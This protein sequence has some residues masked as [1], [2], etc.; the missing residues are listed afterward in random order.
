MIEA[1]RAHPTNIVS[2]SKGRV[3][4]N[5]PKLPD[6]RLTTH[7]DL[8][9]QAGL[10]KIDW[11]SRQ[12]IQRMFRIERSRGMRQR[13]TAPEDIETSQRAIKEWIQNH[14]LNREELEKRP[15]YAKLNKLLP[16]STTQLYAITANDS[17]FP[18][19][20]K[21]RSQ[22]VEGWL[23]MDGGTPKKVHG[24]NEEKERYELA[25][26]VTLPNSV[27][28]PSPVE[29]TLIRSRP[30]RNGPRNL[31]TSAIRQ[32]CHMI[33]SQDGEVERHFYSQNEKTGDMQSRRIIMAFLDNENSKLGINK[34]SVKA[35]EEAGFELAK[36]EV[37][38]SDDERKSGIPDKDMYVL[39]WEKLREIRESIEKNSQ[40]ELLQ[41]LQSKIIPS[42]PVPEKNQ[43]EELAEIRQRL[44]HVS[45][46]K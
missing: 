46:K 33:A 29:L 7:H 2:D 10:R 18:N 15:K 40:S 16:N 21:R 13:I 5:K 11:N 45:S 34:A 44:A 36:K 30:G 9:E 25:M 1:G 26:N 17:E 6:S 32:A 41:K 3:T 22:K 20:L 8:G 37:F 43:Q 27:N 4:F 23:R 24:K 35:F 39:N 31:A 28:Y 14:S 42:T 19:S 12:D 38:W